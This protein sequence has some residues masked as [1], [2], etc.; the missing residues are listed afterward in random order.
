MTRYLLGILFF[1]ISFS[2]IAEQFLVIKFSSTSS[3]VDMGDA[4]D[5]SD[6]E[7]EPAKEKKATYEEDCYL[8]FVPNPIVYL[9][10]SLKQYSTN[11]ILFCSGYLSRPF[12]PPD[13]L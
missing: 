4:S 3:F 2:I 6:E 9:Y 11:E 13:L 8:R 5:S 10:T 7:T 12:T 1:L